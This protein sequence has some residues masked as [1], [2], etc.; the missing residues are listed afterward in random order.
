MV[1]LSR[2]GDADGR[3]GPFRRTFDGR[4]VFAPAAA[5]LARRW[6]PGVLGVDVDPASLVSPPADVVRPGGG[7]RPGTAGLGW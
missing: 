3:S 6:R 2:P 7:R 5:H 1:L 4:D